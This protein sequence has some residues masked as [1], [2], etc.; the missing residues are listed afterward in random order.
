MATET[1]KLKLEKQ[2]GTEKASVTVLNTNL[3]K[4]DAFAKS[5]GD[6]RI[7]ASTDDGVEPTER[8]DGTTLQVGDLWADASE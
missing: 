2:A 8:A 7:V 6:V 5:V 4:I 1:D 3:D